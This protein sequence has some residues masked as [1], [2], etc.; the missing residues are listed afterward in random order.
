MK[1]LSQ[2]AYRIVL[3]ADNN[4]EIYTRLTNPLCQQLVKRFIKGKAVF[5]EH[6]ANCS[7]MQKIIREAVKIVR[8]CDGCTP[9]KAERKEAGF[10]LAAS[11]IEQA[12][13]EAQEMIHETM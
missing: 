9:S 8:K 4:R 6:L 3:Y 7:T 10:A 13:F 5:V 1:E 2:N 12:K 11:L